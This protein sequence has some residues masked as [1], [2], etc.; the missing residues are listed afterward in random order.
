MDHFKS[1]AFYPLKTDVRLNYL[2]NEVG[3]KSGLERYKTW[4]IYCKHRIVVVA[5]RYIRCTNSLRYTD[6]G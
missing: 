3:K 5:H 6:T 2:Q 1:V 4:N